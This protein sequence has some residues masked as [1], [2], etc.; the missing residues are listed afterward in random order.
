MDPEGLGL[1]SSVIGFPPSLPRHMAGY[2]YPPAAPV[3]DSENQ[4]NNCEPQDNDAWKIISGM[5]DLADHRKMVSHEIYF[6]GKLKL[7]NIYSIH[8]QD[9]FVRN[10]TYRKQSRFQY[11]AIH[12]VIRRLLALLLHSCQ[13]DA[14]R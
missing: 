2:G 8:L 4:D 13:P 11:G 5:F 12:L 7:P 6:S 10:H 3:S 1:G 9:I 14:A